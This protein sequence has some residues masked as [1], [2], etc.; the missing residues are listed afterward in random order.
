M[1]R[2]ECTLGAWFLARAAF[3]AAISGDWLAL[4][5]EGLNNPGT[6]VPELSCRLWRE[7]YPMR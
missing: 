2:L 7:Y 6:L 3:G 5:K 4:L 1:R